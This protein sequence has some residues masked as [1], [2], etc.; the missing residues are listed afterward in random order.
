MTLPFTTP[1]DRLCILRLS[2]IGDIC[3]ALPVVRTIQHH[4]PNTRLTWIIGKTEYS[5]VNDIPD[6][7]FIVFDKLLGWK[8]YS[9][10][11]KKLK[12]SSF[13]ALLHMQMSLRASLISL[14]IDT[15]IKLGF[16]RKRAK[17][18][19][20]LFS[21]HKIE[22]RS[23]QHVID[24]FFGFTEALG[25]QERECRWDIPI[26][27]MAATFAEQ[28]LPGDQPTLVIS[29]CSSMAYRNWNAKGYAEIVDYAA[30]KHDLRVVLTGGAE[31]I[32]RKYAEQITQLAQNPVINL[33]GK[34]NLKQLLAVL[35]RSTAL[36]S[37]DAGTAHLATAVNLPVIGLY[38][39][40]NPDRA[41]PY[42][43]KDYVVNKY[44]EAVM[45]KYHKTVE[46]MPWGTRVRDEGT[47]N[48]IRTD[49]VKQ[50][51]DKLLK[52]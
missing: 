6:I 46:D 45:D 7:E 15:P 9:E 14:L 24:S 11:R 33:I 52:V 26:P 41:R 47:M 1:P 39:T 25:I 8:A 29:P 30:N 5:L 50:V 10:L 16:D 38:A 51:L 44:P 4:W 40:T 21:N 13:D 31:L 12:G 32:E 17:D 23:N 3:H 49:D 22:A 2:A 37:P 36:I 20:W 34:T 28:N 43:C 42:L 18:M 48:R 27:E 19:Q 35:Q